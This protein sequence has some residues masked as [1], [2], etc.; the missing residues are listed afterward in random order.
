MYWELL[1]YLDHKK[2]TPGAKYRCSECGYII[3]DMFIQ[4]WK[5]VGW[6]P[7]K[8]PEFVG[9]C[10]NCEAKTTIEEYFAEQDKKHEQFVKKMD[11]DINQLWCDL[12]TEKKIQASK[13]YI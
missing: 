3:D 4:K 6:L 2:N 8:L 10:P 1:S 11:A 12:I 13:K 9:K 7:I 5:F